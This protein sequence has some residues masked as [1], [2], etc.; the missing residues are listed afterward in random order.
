MATAPKRQ[1]LEPERLD[2]PSEM[3]FGGEELSAE[4]L[5]QLD[6]MRSGERS[7]AGGD[8]GDGEGSDEVDDG[9]HG[10]GDGETELARAEGDGDAG[11]AEGRQ[12]D[13][14]PTPK[15]I[16]YGRY[17]REKSA[18]EKRLAEQEAILNAERE[19]RKKDTERMTRL[20][21][22]TKMLLDAINAKPKVAAEEAKGPEDPEPD[23]NDDPLGHAAWVGRELKREREARLALEKDIREGRQ[24]AEAQSEEQRLLNDYSSEIELAARSDPAFADAFV[25]L[26]ETR[27]RELG[28]IYAGIDILDPKECATLSQEDQAALSRAIQQS[29][30]NEQLMVA[31]EARQKR[32]PVARTIMNLARARGF[33]PKKAEAEPASNGSQVPAK[34]N[35]A[36]RRSVGEEIASIREGAQAA[37]SLSDA[38]GSPGGAIDLS[39]LADMSDEEFEEV[40][41]SIPKAKFDRMMGKTQN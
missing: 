18:L 7:D 39:R 16:N 3:D 20:D 9:A 29:F 19:G 23:E 35:G 1:E 15:T 34:K 11:G 40:Y 36:A 27:Y 24:T 33:T 25:H 2:D 30:S 22:R 21:E 4:E 13:K 37:K 41:N 12:P 31:K 6:A 5:A 26:R 32:M 8:A 17:Q 38:G 14:R 28:F 10:V